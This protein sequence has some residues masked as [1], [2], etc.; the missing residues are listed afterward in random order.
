[1]RGLDLFGLCLIFGPELDEQARSRFSYSHSVY[2]VEC[3]RNLQFR[4]GSSSAWSIAPAPGW[5]SRS[6]APC[7]AGPRH[8]APRLH[9]RPVHVQGPLL[10]R[11]TEAQYSTRQAAYGLRKV[12]AKALISKPGRSRRYQVAPTAA[13]TI[14]ALLTLRD[15][16]IVSLLAG[17]GS[18]W[19]G[20]PP[21][22]LTP[23]DRHYE[24][25]RIDM[26]ALFTDLGI[27]TAA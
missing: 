21:C 3:S 9:R 6:C 1:M 27:A 2:Q 13:R 20:H 24:T 10:D 23:A 11:P 17:V 12:R 16:V 14:S 8:R 18:P 7:S 22:T 5:T 19:V 15:Q 4:I 26:E 25:L